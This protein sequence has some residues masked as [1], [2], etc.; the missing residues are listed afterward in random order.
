MLAEVF[1][2]LQACLERRE[3]VVL[4][5]VVE[6]PGQGSQM[7]VWPTGETF[8]DLGSPR[9]NQRAAL[10]AEQTLSGL[11]SSRKAFRW[12]GEEVDVFF[13]VHAPPSEIVIVGAVHV[14][15]ALVE[16][17]KILGYRVV[18]IDPRAAFATQERFHQADLLLNQWPEEAL[19][20]VE[21]HEASCLVV[22]SHDMKIDLPALEVGL[23]SRCRYVGA[24]GSRKTHAKRV[25]ALEE[26]GFDAAAI[27]RIHSPIGLDL[28]GRQAEE[29]ALA[30]LAEMVA[31]GY[32]KPTLEPATD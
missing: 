20:R 8:G 16:L 30:I 11:Q 9:L 3:L 27:H 14:A 7:L 2:E 5:T 19:Q 25:R 18:V 10:F 4:A 12:D 26:K 31:A 28:G 24:L 21:L 13:E 6:G 23:G 17:A 29:I 1:S 22:L 15:M 32:G